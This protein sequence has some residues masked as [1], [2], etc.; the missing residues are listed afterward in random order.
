MVAALA[1]VDAV[2]P[3]DLEHSRLVDVGGEDEQDRVGG[4]DPRHLIAVGE[5]IETAVDEEDDRSIRGDT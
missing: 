4:Q 2:H 3:L 5:S 1:H